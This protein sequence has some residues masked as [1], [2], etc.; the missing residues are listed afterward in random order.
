MVFPHS[1]LVDELIEEG[2]NGDE[3]SNCQRLLLR[4]NLCVLAAKLTG[5]YLIIIKDH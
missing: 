2:R 1:N 3:L 4:K 5:R